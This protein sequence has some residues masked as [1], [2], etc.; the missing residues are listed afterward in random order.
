MSETITPAPITSKRKILLALLLI[1]LLVSNAALLVTVWNQ[2]KDIRDLKA[3]KSWGDKVYENALEECHL[4]QDKYRS[5][6][7]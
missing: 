5:E 6:A 1:V 2:R 3:W 7:K 4:V